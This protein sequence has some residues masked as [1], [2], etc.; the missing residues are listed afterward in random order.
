MIRLYAELSEYY[1]QASS[2]TDANQEQPSESTDGS[3]KQDSQT[4]QNVQPSWKHIKRST[5]VDDPLHQ[6]VSCDICGSKPLV[7]VR[8]KCLVCKD[9]DLCSCCV[10]KGIHSSEH[11]MM[12]SS[13]PHVFDTWRILTGKYMCFVCELRV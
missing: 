3:D 2:E 4:E 7:G 5:C 13:N 11:E 1:E 10:K 6:G 9:Y 12:A 8:F